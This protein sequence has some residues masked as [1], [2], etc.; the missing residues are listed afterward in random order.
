MTA[1]HGIPNDLLDRLLI[2]RTMPYSRVEV[3]QILQL[4]AVTEGINIAE[5]ALAGLSDIGTRTTLRYAVQLLTPASLTARINSRTHISQ[6]DINEVNS[7]FLDAKSSAKIL[8]DQ[9]EKF[10]K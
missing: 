4:R 9:K 1:A 10:M 8:S 5:E 2:I 3:E 6:E 7:L